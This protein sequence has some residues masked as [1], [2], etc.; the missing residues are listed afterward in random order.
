[1]NS[2]GRM[3]FGVHEMFEGVSLEDTWIIGWRH[4]HDRVIVN[5]EASLW[6]GHHDYELPRPGEWTCYKRG[7]L[8]FEAVRSVSGLPST[9]SGVPPYT[10]A[11]GE[12]DF[13]SINYLTTVE[14]GYR[15]GFD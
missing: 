13:G 9:E 12:R 14:D 4:D 2:L 3:P 7:R 15:L 1:M 6:P 10:D 11:S 5:V 8:V